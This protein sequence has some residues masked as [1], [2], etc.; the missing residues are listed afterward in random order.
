MSELV[1][2]YPEAEHGVLGAIM[3]ASLDGDHALADDIVSQMTSGDF[4][5]DDHAALFDVIQDCR[6][7]G[8]PVDPVTVGDVQRQ[9]PSGRGTLSFAAEPEQQRSIRGQRHGLC[10]AGQAV[11][12]DPPSDRHWSLG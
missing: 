12:C 8:M 9:L 7:R 5:Y 6:G 2:G 11:G 1:M 10:Q 3:L 4:L